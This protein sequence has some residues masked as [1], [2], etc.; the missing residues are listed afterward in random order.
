M[1]QA[2]ELLEPC[3]AG[4]PSKSRGIPSLKE[5]EALH[6]RVREL[7]AR[8]AAVELQAELA[9]TMPQNGRPPWLNAYEKAKFEVD[10][11]DFGMDYVYRK[12]FAE[13]GRPLQ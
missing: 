13:K 11:R 3:T 12:Y 10:F 6:G 8:A 4:R 2:L 1:Q 7:E 5:V 9:R